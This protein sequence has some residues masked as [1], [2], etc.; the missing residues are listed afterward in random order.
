[1]EKINKI[2]KSF[3]EEEYISLYDSVSANNADKSS[4]L[5]SFAREENFIDKECIELLAIKPNAF[6]TLKSRL[7]QKI[8]G[9][10]ISKMEA[11]K[12][13]LIRKV[14][15]ASDIILNTDKEITTVMLKKLEKE[16]L[17]YDLPYEL[18][19]IY[20]NLK[21][22]HLNHPEQ[23]YHYSQLYNK[24]VAYT[25]AIDKAE[26]LVGSYFNT[27]SKYYMS[28]DTVA[29]LQLQLM[30][31]ELETICA[32]YQSHRLFTYN[33]IVKVFHILFVPLEEGTTD[34]LGDIEDILSNIE[35]IFTKY[36][37]DSF[38]LLISPVFDFLRF[39]YYHKLGLSKKE[40][41]YFENVNDNL[42]KFL[43]YFNFYVFPAQFLFSKIERFNNL[44]EE[45]NLLPELESIFND[46]TP[47]KSELATFVG[48]YLYKAVAYYSTEDYEKSARTLN[49]IRNEVSFK[50]YP[51]IEIEI[52]LM[53]AL[54]YCMQKEYDMATQLIKSVQRQIRNIPEKEYLGAVNFMKMLNKLINQQPD[55]AKSMH[56]R[57]MQSNY[58][59]DA[60][61]K[62]IKVRTNTF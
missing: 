40:T 45:K 28:R 25:L 6:Y 32:L 14:S 59:T 9:F 60:V 26:D 12:M 48:F 58:G 47:D 44:N 1:M 22:L 62:Y 41:P 3:S 15:Y 18:T 56:E 51:H 61:L 35:D 5:L 20:Q 21:K 7:N 8:E 34:S 39:E 43:K 10:L 17:D 55:K 38:Y 2:V 24:H 30:K 27:Y 29:L 33:S 46:F 50:K 57:F 42:V 54:Q 13:D 37:N 31:K 11:P 16:L 19:K 4:T 23:H 36:E 49:H 53:L 52:K